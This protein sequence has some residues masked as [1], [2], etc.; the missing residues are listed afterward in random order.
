MLIKC[1]ACRAEARLPESQEGAK[2]RCG[3]CEKVYVARPRGSRSKHKDANTNARLGI[4]TGAILVLGVAFVIIRRSSSGDPTPVAAAEA[5]PSVSALP[6]QAPAAAVS[7]WES[8]PVRAVRDVYEAV[9]AYD[10]QRVLGRLDL[11][12]LH[13]A[14]SSAESAGGAGQ[15][16]FGDLSALEVAEFR[17]ASLATLTDRTAPDAIG[18]WRPF[19][20][21]VVSESDSEALVYVKVTGLDEETSLETRTIA[22]ELVRDPRDG[23]RW[24]VAGWERVLTAA[25]TRAVRVAKQARVERVELSD[26]SKVFEAIPEPLAHLES[27]PQELRARIDTLYV[28]LVD[29]T[30]SPRKNADAK[31][32]LVEIGGPALPVLLTGLYEIKL[33]TQ[34]QAIQVNLINQCLEEITGYYTGYKP[35]IMEGSATGTSAERR[36]SAVK[37]WFAWWHRDGAKFLAGPPAEPSK[38]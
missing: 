20:G 18:A 35:Q 33:E 11:A 12:R 24:H 10:D 15:P 17:A 3:E 34:D 19:D 37:Q 26:G 4:L 5:S 9:A 36:E 25:E 2:V 6:P 1:P 7:P 23:G 27:T 31:A 29:L 32:A 16:E 13:A 28:Q 38:E 21:E 14:H 8:D 30:L 22:W